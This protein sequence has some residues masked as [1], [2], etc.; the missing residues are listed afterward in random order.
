MALTKKNVHMLPHNPIPFNN[1]LAGKSF[2][3]FLIQNHPL[4]FHLTSLF[5]LSFNSSL[6]LLFGSKHPFTLVRTHR[7]ILHW[8][9]SHLQVPLILSNQWSP[10]PLLHALS[11]YHVLSYLNNPIFWTCFFTDQHSLSHSIPSLILALRNLPCC[12]ASIV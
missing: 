6:L 11:F 10:P 1:G 2:Y 7:A 4:P 3:E 5:C 12:L 8:G 9:Q